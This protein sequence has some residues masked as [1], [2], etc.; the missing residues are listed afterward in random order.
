MDR[1]EHSCQMRVALGH[2][3]TPRWLWNPFVG[4]VP[5]AKS[6]LWALHSRSFRGKDWRDVSTVQTQGRNIRHYSDYLTA[7]ATGYQ[8]T[9]VDYVLNAEGRLKRLT[10]DKGLLRETEC[11]QRQIHTLVKCD[12]GVHLTW[13][14]PPNRDLLV[15]Q[16]LTE[17]PENEITLTAFRL[18]VMDLLALF[19]VMNEGAMNVLGKVNDPSRFLS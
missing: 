14:D 11:V 7:R 12:V 10:V 15:S 19:S 8:K 9:K 17:E 6:L 5:R 13:V 18:L 3:T 1:I 4:H 2:V 16:L